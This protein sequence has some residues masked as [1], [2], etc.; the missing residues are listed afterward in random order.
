VIGTRQPFPARDAQTKQRPFPSPRV[1]LSRRLERYYGRLRRPP[2]TPPTSRL[3]T[4][5][6][7]RRSGASPQPPGRGG[8]PQFPPSPSERSAPSTPGGSSG[9]HSRLFAPSVAFAVTDAARLLLRPARPGTVTARQASL[10]CYGPLSRSPFKGFRRW[11]PTRPVTRPSR[12]PATGPPG[13]YPDG[14]HTR[15]QRRAYVGSGH[16]NRPPP[17]AGHTPIFCV[18]G[19]TPAVGLR[20]GS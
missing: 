11:A 13:S 8:P 2:G 6:R 10:R 19:F 7:A 18:S 12:Q 14:T 5:Y 1:L 3:S 17:T 9:L 16:I 20:S 15:R 4:G